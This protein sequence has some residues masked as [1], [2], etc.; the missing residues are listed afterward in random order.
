MASESVRPPPSG[1]GNLKY[2]VIGLLLL[3]GAVGLYFAT[4][5]TPPPPVVTTAVDAGILARPTALATNDLEIPDPLPDAGPPVDAG[6]PRIRYVTRYVGGGGTNWDCS[7]DIPAARIT[8]VINEYRSQVRN[9][10]ERRLKVNNTLTGTLS[11]T[12]KVDGAGRVE[13]TN[14]GGSLRD[15]EV[16][17][18]VRSIATGMRFPAPSGGSCAV[19]NA[20]FN[21]SPR[22]Q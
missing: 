8:Q 14:V 9:C 18:C 19:V 15:N 6:G 16:F 7:G 13:A 20:P 5:T 21:F 2:A 11:L 1:G 10:Y 3:L 17:S 12:M 4:A 22:A